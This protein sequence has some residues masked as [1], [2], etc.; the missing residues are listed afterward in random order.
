MIR[1]IPECGV[2]L[3]SSW[4]FNCYLIE[5]GGAGRPFVV[6]AGIPANGKK[7]LREMTGTLGLAPQ[8]LSSILATHTHTDHCAGAPGLHR[9]TG[10]PVYF[11]EKV[12]DYLSGE[13]ARMFPISGMSRLAPILGEGH[14]EWR[15]LAEWLAASRSEGVGAT[16]SFQFSCPVGGFLKDG[17]PLSGAPD[18][19]VLHT[20]G[21]SDCSI[22]FW[23]EKTKT[24]LS[25]DTVLSVEGRAWFNP[26]HVEPALMEKTEERLRKLPVEHLLPGHGRPIH[27]AGFM[28][29]AWSHRDRVKGKPFWTCR[30]RQG[31]N[32]RG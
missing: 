27:G 3:A 31:A 24:L 4:I 29:N 30:A 14:F 7:I 12:R 1:Q 23:N 20:P 19:K 2:R 15:A 32:A 16:P 26:E 13:K 6:D 28:G 11:H 8:G 17:E 22:C 5:D 10:A 21:H 25:G 18:W 9:K